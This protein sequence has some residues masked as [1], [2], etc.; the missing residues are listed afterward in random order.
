MVRAGAKALPRRWARRR[1]ERPSAERGRRVAKPSLPCLTEE[2]GV[3][4]RRSTG[5]GGE[6]QDAQARGGGSE[7]H[8][9]GGEGTARGRV[10]EQPR[11]DHPPAGT[12]LERHERRLRVGCRRRPAREPP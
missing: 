2:F 12:P 10:E 8:E 1:L 3:P 6:E 5:G 9:G 11:G 7:R 4:T